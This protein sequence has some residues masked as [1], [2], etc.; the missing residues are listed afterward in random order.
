[1]DVSGVRRRLAAA[2]GEVRRALLVRRRLLSA[3]CAAVAVLATLRALAPPPEPTAQTLVAVRHLAAGSV[4]APGDVASEALPAAAVPDDAAEAPV[5]RTLA[6]AVGA[7]EVLTDA[8]LVGPSLLEGRPGAVA[9]PVR[10]P[11]ADVVALLRVGDRVDL[12]AADPAAADPLGTRLLDA[13]LVLALPAPVSRD[14]R[15]GRL[16][17]LQVTPEQGAEIS[18][19]AARCLLTVALAR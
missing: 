16:V 3:V 4:V 18:G 8:R 13:A 15:Q 10:I 14:G 17:V 1:M 9:L 7:G 12:Y 2:A 6:A 5:G 11:D 19:H